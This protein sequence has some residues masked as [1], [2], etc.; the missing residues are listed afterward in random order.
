MSPRCSSK[1]PNVQIEKL[2][3]QIKDL[4]KMIKNS[5]CYGDSSKYYYKDYQNYI[6]YVI[7]SASSVLGD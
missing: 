6:D 5:T 1:D 3:N 7:D 4:E 2:S